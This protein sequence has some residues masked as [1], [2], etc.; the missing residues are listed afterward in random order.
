MFRKLFHTAQFLLIAFSIAGCTSPSLIITFDGKP[1]ERA[2]SLLD[3]LGEQGIDYQLNPHPMPRQLTGNT[4][5]YPINF[6]NPHEIDKVLT[7][8][9]DLQ[10]DI[11]LE[12]SPYKNNY[13]TDGQYGLYIFLDTRRRAD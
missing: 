7:L 6:S 8:L 2:E 3:R 4:L 10:F 11:R 9:D 12:H 13:Y 5:I 1:N